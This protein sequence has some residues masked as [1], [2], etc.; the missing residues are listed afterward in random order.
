MLEFR[1]F[2]Q[3]YYDSGAEIVTAELMAKEFLKETQKTIKVEDAKVVMKEQLNMS[4][5]KIVKVPVQANSEV[6]LILRQRAAI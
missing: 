1:D 6:N 2:A 4:Y 3:A 5:S